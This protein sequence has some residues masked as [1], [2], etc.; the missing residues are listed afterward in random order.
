MNCLER[1]LSKVLIQTVFGAPAMADNGQLI[2]VLSGPKASID[3][4]TPYCKG[5]MGRAEIRFDDEPVGKALTLKLIG[6]TMI[7][8]MVEALA[9]AHVLAEKT[10]LGTD[11]LHSFIETMFPGPYVA[12]SNR[13]L[14]GDYY[15]RDEVWAAKLFCYNGLIFASRYSMSMERARMLATL[16]I[17]RRERDSA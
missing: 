3:K 2:C 4:V 13:M 5:V 6:N 9:E 7:L 11:H 16:E 15:N 14:N 17:L 12:Y 8:Q 10:G 1:S